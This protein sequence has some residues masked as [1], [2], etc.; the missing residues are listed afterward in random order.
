[1]SETH[2]VISAFLDDEPF[3]ARALAEAL[4]EPAGRELLIDLIALRH[5]TH[6]DG[7]DSAAIHRRPRSALRALAAAAVVL[8]ALAGG[9][10]AGE[11]QGGA[12]IAGAPPATR[13][14]QAPAPWQEAPAGRLR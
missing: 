5:L 9:Y 7:R 1:M 4:S 12:T 10:L 13:V 2:D 8:V 14:V 6:G 11:R 3:D